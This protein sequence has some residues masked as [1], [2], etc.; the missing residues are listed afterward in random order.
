MLE[1]S[2]LALI[3]PRLVLFLKP[4]GYMSVTVINGSI[5]NIYRLRG[6]GFR[7]AEAFFFYGCQGVIRSKS[8]TRS[9][10]AAQ[11]F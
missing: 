6:K 11:V 3:F 10:R 4:F 5:I 2:S 9:V 7:I 8:A 1:N